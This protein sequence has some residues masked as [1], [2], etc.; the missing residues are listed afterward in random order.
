MYALTVRQP[1]AYAILHLGKDVENRA[2]PVRRRETIVIHSA[3]RPFEPHAAAAEAFR[4]AGVEIP[5]AP[6]LIFGHVLGV[7]DVVGCHF[8]QLC[9]CGPWAAPGPVWHWLLAEPRLLPEPFPLRGRQGLWP[10]DGALEL[11][12]RE[13]LR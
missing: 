5:P 9:S 3:Q 10:L 13:Q 11:R 1:F 6:A 12:V 2:M 8:S 4:N 7:A